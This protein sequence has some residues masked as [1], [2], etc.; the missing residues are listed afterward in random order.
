MLYGDFESEEKCILLKTL[1]ES[2]LVECPTE[3]IENEIEEAEEVTDKIIQNREEIGSVLPATSSEERTKETGDESLSRGDKETRA[4]VE[5][6]ESSETCDHVERI[7]KTG[8][9]DERDSKY[10]VTPVVA[11]A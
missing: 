8:A 2:I 7:I 11:R 9:P 10:D 6:C 1:D 3:E 4:T 5:T